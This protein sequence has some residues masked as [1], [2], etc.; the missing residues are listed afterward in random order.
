MLTPFSLLGPWLPALMAGHPGVQALAMHPA[1][2]GA[3]LSPHRLADACKT[4]S[5]LFKS[6]PFHAVV[7]AIA[8]IDV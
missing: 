5:T 1:P 3:V 6:H 7:N 4:P 8:H 2:H